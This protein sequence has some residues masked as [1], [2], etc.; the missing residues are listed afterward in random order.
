MIVRWY[1]PEDEPYL[2]EIERLSPRGEPRPFVHFRRRFVDR[3]FLYEDPHVFIAEED[4]RPIGMTSIAIKRTRI[5]DENVRVAYSFDTRVH[6][7]YRRR[8]V[9]NAMQEEKL[10][11]LRS[12]GVHAI[13]AYVVATNYMAIE[14]LEKVNFHRTRM[15]L[16]LTFPPYP[17]IFSPSVEPL[18]IRHLGDYDLVHDIHCQ[19]DLYIPDVAS[20]VQDFNFEW[21]C[22]KPDGSD[23]MSGL[24]LFDQSM[25]Y[26]Q[27]SADEP[28]PTEEE[29][30]QRARTLRIFDE[31]GINQAEHLR[32]VFDSIRDYAV[33][34]NVARFTWLIDRNNPV[35]RFVF[36][37]ASGQKDY[38]M[39][40]QSL[41]PD[42][43][44][45][46]K[47]GPIYVDARD[48]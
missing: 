16:H 18:R 45:Q 9:A 47:S 27:V 10:A 36:E 12:E 28:W 38:W 37:D 15:I 31:T 4:G 6:P 8:G 48:L 40:F 26:Q 41:I 13:Y 7:A 1:Q 24:S 17:M 34:A 43:E 20:S 23:S 3:A 21:I 5:G 46:W 2:M 22:V 42:W 30:S 44:P 35:P 29:I 19:R 11:F 14:M 33:T 32:W 25:V 39:L